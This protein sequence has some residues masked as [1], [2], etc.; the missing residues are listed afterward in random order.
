MELSIVV[1]RAH[2]DDKVR[3]GVQVPAHVVSGNDDLDGAAAEELLDN[4]S[5]VLRHGLVEEANA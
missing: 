4:L 2:N 5:L 1:L 3:A